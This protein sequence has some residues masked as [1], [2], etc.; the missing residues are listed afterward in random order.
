LGQNI[1]RSRTTSR[2]EYRC[3]KQWCEQSHFLSPREPAETADLNYNIG[4]LK[5][6]RLLG[7]EA[8][9]WDSDPDWM[10]IAKRRRVGRSIR[11]DHLSIS[12]QSVVAPN[13][14]P[15]SIAR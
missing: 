1:H 3:R 10:L 4:R 13:K 12:A 5:Q 7:R 15:S 8:Q 6:F 11:P 14:L 9:R 2:S